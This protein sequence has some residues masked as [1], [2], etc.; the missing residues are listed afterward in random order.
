MNGPILHKYV[1][2]GI[3][4]FTNVT[5]ASGERVML[6]V[7]AEEGFAVFRL[8]LG[9]RVPGKR[10]FDSTVQDLARMTRVIARDDGTLP[11]LPQA[12]D[13]HRDDG[14][15]L[16]FLEAANAD[17]GAAAEGRAIPGAVDAFDPEAPPPRPLAMVTRLALVAADEADLVRRYERARNTPA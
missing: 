6:S 10:V 5:L 9:G 16:T 15:M 3:A 13:E 1:D 14:A 11:P 12:V 4:C 7:A 8:H 2:N 17:V